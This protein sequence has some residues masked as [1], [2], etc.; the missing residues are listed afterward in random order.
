MFQLT[1]DILEYFLIYRKRDIT[2]YMS[3]FSMLKLLLRLLLFF[4]M[5]SQRMPACSQPPDLVEQIDCP[6]S[7]LDARRYE[8]L[9]VKATRQERKLE[10]TA[11]WRKERK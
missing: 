4:I 5:N 10:L 3:K 7:F 1:K 6:L 11:E 2:I 8:N 9:R